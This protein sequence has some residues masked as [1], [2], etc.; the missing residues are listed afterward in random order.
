MDVAD[1][2]EEHEQ[3]SR[4]IAIDFATSGA[5]HKDGTSICVKCKEPNDRWRDG[6]AV[7][8]DCVETADDR[9]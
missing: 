5:V 4:D 1:R 6:Y 9:Y 3:K 2:A 8:T 7:C